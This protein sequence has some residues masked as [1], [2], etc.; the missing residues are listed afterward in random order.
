MAAFR[1]PL[2]GSAFYLVCNAGLGCILGSVF[3]LVA[4]RLYSPSAIGLASAAVSILLL[5]A[6]LCD[7]G[8]DYAQMRFVPANPQDAG[9]IAN[10]SF[11]VGGVVSLVAGLVFLGGLGVWAPQF[12]RFN[13]LPAVIVMFA[14]AAPAFT[15]GSLVDATL[16]AQGQ[17][18][19]V[20]LKN[21]AANGF[22]FPLALGFATFGAAGLFTSMT[23]AVA[24]AA[25]LSVLALR[26]VLPTYRYT[27]KLDRAM[28]RRL[29]PYGL[30]NHAVNIVSSLPSLLLP[31]IVL[32]TSGA[33][34]SGRFAIAWLVVQPITMVQAS[35][36]A[37]L[38]TEGSRVGQGYAREVRRALA[39][40]LPAVGGIILLGIVLAGP[41]LGLFGRAYAAQDVSLLRLL[42]AST[43]PAAINSIFQAR[44]RIERRAAPIACLAAGS[45]SITFGSLSLLLPHWGLAGVGLAVA[46]GQALPAIGTGASLLRMPRR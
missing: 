38:L 39:L 12:L 37:A 29:L 7:L 42:L 40:M 43:L 6:T 5:L 3:W 35:V 1:I 14:L 19:L 24:L 22:R 18:R 31:V 4:A 21:A 10:L 15:I 25:L 41:V 11:T 20:V 9:P 13:D 17:S 23:A 16:I 27:P 36:S 8:L 33:V 46:A 26:R 44:C 28:L 2:I 32:G 45:A 30:Q 34:I